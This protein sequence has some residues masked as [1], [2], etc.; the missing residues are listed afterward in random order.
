M[1]PSRRGVGASFPAFVSYPDRVSFAD[2]RRRGIFPRRENFAP[3]GHDSP[4]ELVMSPGG[5][6]PQQNV[7]SPRFLVL[8]DFSF[9]Q[10]LSAA[11]TSDELQCRQVNVLAAQVR[12]PQPSGIRSC[13]AARP[14]R[15]TGFLP[16]I[17]LVHILGLSWRPSGRRDG[18]RGT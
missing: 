9:H 16:D 14:G 2:R 17:M 3:F 7:G 4:Q 13:Q 5:L 12:S 6:V 11:G 1:Q 15:P 10:R 18:A 8:P